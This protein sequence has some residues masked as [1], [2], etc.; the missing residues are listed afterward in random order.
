MTANCSGRH[1]CLTHL[2]RRGWSD[3][4]GQRLSGAQRE[5]CEIEVV[6]LEKPTCGF[7]QNRKP[8]EQ[9]SCSQQT[10][11]LCGT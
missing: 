11:L 4:W 1:T 10:Q 7:L 3:P 5:E 6:R 9:A 2:L 8:Q